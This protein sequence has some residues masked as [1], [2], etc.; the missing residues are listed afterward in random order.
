MWQAAAVVRHF[1]RSAQFL[2]HSLPRS[3]SIYPS[4]PRS[5]S[6]FF[7]LFFSLSFHI[8]HAHV[9][10][11]ET[12]CTDPDHQIKP[13]VSNSLTSPPKNVQTQVIFQINF[14]CG[15]YRWGSG[16]S[17]KL[18]SIVRSICFCFRSLS[19][20]FRVSYRRHPSLNL[21]ARQLLTAPQVAAKV[22]L[23]IFL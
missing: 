9:I 4:L 19:L 23:N 10:S 14:S 1:R 8:A 6:V 12:M 20:S 5:L 17:K 2:P 11:S 15:V 7:S 13:F 16:A 21:F 22:V 3:S 18:I